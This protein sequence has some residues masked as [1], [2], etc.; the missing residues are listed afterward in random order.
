L[1]FNTSYSFN[2]LEF[3]LTDAKTLLRICAKRFRTIKITATVKL[4]TMPKLEI[5]AETAVKRGLRPSLRAVITHLMR[6]QNVQSD[7]CVV[8]ADDAKLRALKLE[9]WNEDATTDVLSFPQWE[10]GDPFVP[11]VL[12]DIV[13]S[14]PTAQ[15]QANARG[16]SLETEVVVL[17][18]HG[19]THLLG[20]DH[21]TEPEW[22]VFH[23]SE[24][25]AIALLAVFNAGKKP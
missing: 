1:V 24:R 9:F 17:A 13:I 25:Q 6:A 10:P 11:E 18:A 7:V 21:Q 5:I 20:F 19:L 8:L 2:S 12:G 4:V 22:G 16:H 14:L 3:N 23:E 15:V